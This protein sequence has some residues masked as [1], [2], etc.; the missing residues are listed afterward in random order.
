MY[1]MPFLK[2]KKKK[3]DCNPILIKLC[4]EF[5]YTLYI[6][7]ELL[8]HLKANQLKDKVFVHFFLFS[9]GRGVVEDLYPGSLP[10]LPG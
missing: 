1:V 2:K 7:N 4:L 8:Q 10:L 5:T 6:K 3:K 9:E